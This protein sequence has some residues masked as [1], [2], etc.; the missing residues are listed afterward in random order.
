MSVSVA[1][2][3]GLEREITI[4]I[5]GDAIEAEVDKQLHELLPKANIKGFRPGKVPFKVLKQKF[6]TDVKHDAISKLMQSKLQQQLAES[7]LEPVDMPAINVLND[8]KKPGDSFEFTATFETRPVIDLSIIENLTIEKPVAEPSDE[9]IDEMLEKLRKQQAQWQPV[10]REAR[11]GDKVTIDFLGK[12]DGEPFEGGKA[13]DFELELGSN[14]MIPGFEEGIV[15][16]QI[17]KQQTIQVTFPEQYHAA[18]LAGKATEFDITLKTVQEPSLPDVNDETFLSRFDIKEGGVDKLRA[19][20]K[21]RLQEELNYRLQLKQREALM[22]KLNE[23]TEFE[24]PKGLVKKEL[25]RLKN[26]TNQQLTEAGLKEGMP[27]LP[28]EP[29]QKQAEKNI[30]LQLLL[31]EYAK[32]HDVRLDPAKVHAQ[33]EQIAANYQQ[34]REFMEFYYSNEHLLNGIQNQVFEQQIV[35]KM[36]EQV[37]LTEKSYTYD[38]I[39]NSSNST[40]EQ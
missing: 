19:N 39:M 32:V 9:V 24:L 31:G 13:E 5:P 35:D 7:E 2:K 18:D 15:G 27:E 11:N 12:L 10:E 29:M 8:A 23:V 36:L 14:S 37:N 1:T 4:V 28:E 34:G 33:I 22:T 21:E 30:K 25:E 17:G 38:E 26:Q 40:T 16:L 6:G 20:I 3:E